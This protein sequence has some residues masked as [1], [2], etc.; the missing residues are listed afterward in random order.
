MVYNDACMYGSKQ[1]WV[2]TFLLLLSFDSYS[3]HG[4]EDKKKCNLIAQ[5]HWLKWG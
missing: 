2:Q 3:C 5:E 1:C 4:T